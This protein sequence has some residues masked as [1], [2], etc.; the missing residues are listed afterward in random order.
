[1]PDVLFPTAK[2][3]P[4]LHEDDHPLLEELTRRGVTWACAIWDDPSVDWG[5]AP[6][7]VIRST[8]DYHRRRGEYLAWTRAAA[9]G[10]SPWNAAPVIEWNTHKRDTREPE[11]EGGG[12]VPAAWLEEGGGRG[13][14]SWRSGAAARTP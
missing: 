7:A 2:I 8:W 5:S 6:V 13:R 9:A 10:K 4:G 1:M 11:K 3:H 12:S 14:G